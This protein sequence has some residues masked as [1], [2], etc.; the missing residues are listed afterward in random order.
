MINIIFNYNV[1]DDP[2][3]Q[4]SCKKG[5][6]EIKKLA[7]QVN[8]DVYIIEGKARAT[9]FDDNTATHVDIEYT[10]DLTQ[11]QKQA[12]ASAVQKMATLKKSECGDNP[13]ATIVVFKK[14]EQDD[15][16]VF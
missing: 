11:E 6:A 9:F 10:C 13:P 2:Y 14:V 7:E 1:F 16:F 15:C 4:N 8:Q 12:F 3:N 5:V